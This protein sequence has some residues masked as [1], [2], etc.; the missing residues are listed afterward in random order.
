MVR[1]VL[2]SIVTGGR[3]AQPGRAAPVLGAQDMLA[4]AGLAPRQIGIVCGVDFGE[5]LTERR[6]VCARHS[7]RHCDRLHCGDTIGPCA[8]C[9]RAWTI[10]I[11]IRCFTPAVDCQCVP[12]RHDEPNADLELV[13]VVPA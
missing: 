5:R 2:E 11:C 3:V 12:D 10:S 7:F 1:S 13:R 8:G 9:P 4:D 6:P